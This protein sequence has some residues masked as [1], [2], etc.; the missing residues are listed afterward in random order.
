MLRPGDYLVPDPHAVKTGRH[1][2]FVP[3][4]V[5]AGD[6][7][8]MFI[9]SAPRTGIYNNTCYANEADGISVEGPTRSEAGMAMSINGCRI[10]NNIIAYNKGSQLTMRKNG[11]DKNTAKNLSDYNLFFAPSGHAAKVGWGGPVASS[12]HEWRRLSKQDTHSREGDPNFS[13]TVMGDLR[14]K[15]NSPALGAGEFLSE[16]KTD[17][18]GRKRPGRKISIGACELAALDFPG[19]PFGQFAR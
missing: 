15:P 12:V 18:F 4:K 16:V 2:I 9:S 7:L 10:L 19:F 6:G 17:F 3:K 13:M 11:V 5:T 1:N 8:G 14:L